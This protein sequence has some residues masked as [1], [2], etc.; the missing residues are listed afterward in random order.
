MGHWSSRQGLKEWM[1]SLLA[2][3]LAAELL[4]ASCIS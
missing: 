1:R 3:T 2:L 4:E